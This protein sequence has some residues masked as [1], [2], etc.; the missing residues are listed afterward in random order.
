MHVLDD[1]SEEENTSQF[2][3]YFLLNLLLL[4]IIL[5]FLLKQ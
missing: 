1:E 3:G 2:S 5:Q 4:S